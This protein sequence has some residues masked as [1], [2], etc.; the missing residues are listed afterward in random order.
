MSMRM[1]ALDPPETTLVWTAGVGFVV[2][3]G[4]ADVLEGSRIAVAVPAGG[5]VEATLRQPVLARVTRE[6]ARQLRSRQ[7]RPE[8]SWFGV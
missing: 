8:A 3:G 1:G 7:P 6:C 5:T 4:G 2:M